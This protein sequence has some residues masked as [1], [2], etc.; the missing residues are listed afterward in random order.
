[1]DILLWIF[2]RWIFCRTFLCII[3]SNRKPL[4][5]HA[6]QI[7]AAQTPYNY[8]APRGHVFWLVRGAVNIFSASSRRRLDTPPKPTILLCMIYFRVRKLP[9]NRTRVPGLSIRAGTRVPGNHIFCWTF[10]KNSICIGSSHCKKLSC[11]FGQV[12]FVGLTFTLGRDVMVVSTAG[13]VCWVCCVYTSMIR[14]N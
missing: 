4:V 13:R 8:H 1:M 3:I 5:I 7:A 10:F 14:L 2:H 9:Q 6:T 11:R 12:K